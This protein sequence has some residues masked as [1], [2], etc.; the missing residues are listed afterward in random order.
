MIV[1]LRS[2]WLYAVWRFLLQSRD[3]CLV[4]LPMVY[5]VRIYVLCGKIILL[6]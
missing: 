2:G 5:G 4:R 3:L 6:I 1:L